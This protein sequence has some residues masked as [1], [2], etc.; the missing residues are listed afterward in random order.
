[1]C[2]RPLTPA[3][4]Q[5]RVAEA[6]QLRQRVEDGN[7][8]EREAGLQGI[9]QFVD[10]VGQAAEPFVVPLVPAILKALADK[11]SRNIVLLFTKIFFPPSNSR[12]SLLLRRPTRPTSFLSPCLVFLPWFHKN[13]YNT[14]IRL[15]CT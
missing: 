6:K 9:V 14:L 8:A 10:A 5:H 2:L 12:A 3:E 15:F 13:I 7:G 11:V 4:S 1:M